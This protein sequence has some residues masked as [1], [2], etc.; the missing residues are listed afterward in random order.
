VKKRPEQPNHLPFVPIKLHRPPVPKYH[1]H[2]THF[3]ERIEPRRQR[4]LT[5]ITDP[6]GYGKFILISRWLDTNDCPCAWLSLVDILDGEMPACGGASSLFVDMID[7]SATPGSVAGVHRRD[8]RRVRSRMRQRG[9][10]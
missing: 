5:L 9:M 8:R 7:H 10:G 2:R 1:A 4:P 6:A 3:L